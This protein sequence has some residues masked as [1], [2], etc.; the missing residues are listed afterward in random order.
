MSQEI[1][2]IYRPLIEDMTWSYSRISSFHDCPYKW[3]LRYIKDCKELP[4]FYSSYGSFMHKL[5]EDFYRGRL[6]REE[7]LIKFLSDFQ[8]EV[9]GERPKDSIVKKYIRCGIKYLAGF[10]PF[11]Y[12]TIDVEKRV[13]FHIYGI[14]FV[15]FIDYLGE[16]DNGDLIIIDN[17][18]RSLKPRSEKEKPTA[19]DKELDEMLRQLYI[20]SRAVEEEYGR[21]PKWLCFNCFKS[22]EFIIEPFNEKAYDEA[23]EWAVN[24][25]ETIKDTNDFPPKGDYFSCRFICEVK[26]DC[27]Y[28]EMR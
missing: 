8:E 19:K 16:S 18:S 24:S 12:N 5:I 26:N 4:Q 3:F 9:R 23:I 2:E 14:P 27:C 1:Q 20:Y 28:Y 25:V 6:T 11:P 17:K 21:L 15:G 7:M 13:K 22:G 10:T